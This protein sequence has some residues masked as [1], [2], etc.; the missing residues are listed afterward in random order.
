[1]KPLLTLSPAY[2]PLS[3]CHLAAEFKKQY[4]LAVEMLR[5]VKFWNVQQFSGYVVF[6]EEHG[7]VARKNFIT[8]KLLNTHFN[9]LQAETS[10]PLALLLHT[11]INS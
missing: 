7:H 3:A 11:V 5:I 4:V 8:G 10:L 6:S 2:I 9:T 1:M